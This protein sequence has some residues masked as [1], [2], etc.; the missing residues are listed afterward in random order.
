MDENV[1]FNTPKQ[2][3]PA[4]PPPAGD[5]EAQ[6]PANPA[7][8]T[9]TDM[10]TEEQS[11]GDGTEVAAEEPPP[12]PPFF[13]LVGGGML[14][15]I[16]IGVGIFVIII[17]IVLMLLPKGQPNKQV[18][19]RWW[20]LWEE[21]NAVQSLILDFK[22]THP[23]ITIEYIKNDPNQYKDRLLTRMQNGSGPDIFRYHNTWLPMLVDNL[24]PLSSDAITPDEFKKAYY[25]V[26]QR[27]LTKNGAIY[28][29]PLDADSLV[30]FVNPALFEAAGVQVPSNW[31]DFVKVSKKLTVKDV[32]GKIKTAGAG[33]GTYDNITHAPDI[34]SLLFIQ[35]G[36][37]MDKFTASTKSEA[38][39]L[40]FYT[41]FA[42]GQDSVWDGTLDSSLL[43][44]SKG[45]LAMYFGYSWDVFAIQRLNKDLSF[46]LYPVPELYGK[47]TTIASYWVEG[48]SS[49]SPNQK[50]AMEFMHYLS[51]KE[52]AQ[53]FYT[54][55]A[56][57]RAFGEPYARK[58][59]RDSLH[60][61]PLV[62]PFVSQLDN[63]S[64]SFFASDTHDGDTGIN[65]MMNAYLQ[66]TIGSMTKDASSADSVVDDLNKGV[67]QVLQK[68][69][70][71]QP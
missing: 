49:K 16:L 33:L 5:S 38:D 3:D 27:D 51:Q 25:P 8:D 52:T 57:V 31:D 71:Q 61:N 44:F 55:T 13:G 18:T 65:T 4:N 37:Q 42:N 67:T 70:Q 7:V 29:I 40:Q 58:D 1:V 21:N 62:Y 36:V 12:P 2:D 43:E 56:K 10:P 26:M 32:G 17:I 63:A 60:E 15:K 64:S 30:L 14:K 59:L 6:T 28:G 41:S 69:G 24:S 68:Y 9:S 47:K 11:E 22:K 66:T 54:E 45:N 34:I 48:V 46:K 35:Q 19:L 39:A 23:N 50:E 53:K 20:G